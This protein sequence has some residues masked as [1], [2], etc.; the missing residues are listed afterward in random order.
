LNKKNNNFESLMESLE[1][2]LNFT[3][4]RVANMIGQENDAK[5]EKWDCDH[6]F[7]L[8]FLASLYSYVVMGFRVESDEEP[9]PNTKMIE[10]P[11]P[12]TKTI[13]EPQPNTKTIEEPQPNAKII[14][15][16]QPNTKT[17]EQPQPSVIMYTADFLDFLTN[18]WYVHIL[19]NSLGLIAQWLVVMEHIIFAPSL[20]RF[21][22]KRTFSSRTVCL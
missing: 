21:T 15:E 6:F 16:P 5:E 17:I 14:E 11:Q 12:N 3:V 10:E 8:Q 20:N 13:E 7:E 22:V 1:V 19:T 2:S 9:Q 4:S 18:V